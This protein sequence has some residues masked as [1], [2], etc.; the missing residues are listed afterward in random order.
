M[1]NI[2]QSKRES[3]RFQILVEI[4]AHQPNL[5]QKEVAERLG[6]TPQAIS[7]Y[8][9]ELVAN[10]LVTTDG[11][12]RYSITKEGVEWL[13]EGAAE[14]KR[15][16]RVV[17]EDIISHVSVWTALA[18]S[19]LAEGERVSLEMRGGLLYANR[20]EG[21]EASGIT[22]SDA[23]AGEDVGV[24]D[25]KGLISLD[26]GVIIV[27]KVPR[28]QAG[29]SRKVDV[30]AL[31]TLVSGEKMIGALGVEA[32][33]A[34]RKAGREPDV[35]FGAKESAVEAAFHGINSVIASVDEQVPSL[36]ERLESEGLK[37]ELVDLTTV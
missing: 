1:V 37:Y 5:R 18:E 3:S 22:I 9:K 33:V 17:M 29:G 6:V 16:A 11:R 21:I 4:A 13:L 28:V 34:L 25:L 14:L 20:K 36:L 30:D 12:M 7:E 24:S 15:Y 31:K 19:D 35:I 10:G 27:A 23:R 26:E 2:L 8:I 32:L